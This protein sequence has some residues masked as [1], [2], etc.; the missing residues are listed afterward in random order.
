MYVKTYKY[1]DYLEVYQYENEPKRSR[2]HNIRRDFET[3]SVRLGTSGKSEIRQKKPNATKRKDN[4][5]RA[6]LAFTRLVA[7]NTTVS[8]NPV[9]ASLTYA[10]NMGKIGVAHKDFNAFAKRLRYQPTTKPR[11]HSGRGHFTCFPPSLTR[12]FKSLPEKVP[13]HFLLWFKV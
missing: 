5:G 7:A 6:S 13:C 2:R 1:G 9:M 4:G 11:S 10:E 3:V 8:C 12:N